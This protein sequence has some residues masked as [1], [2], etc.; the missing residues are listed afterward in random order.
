MMKHSGLGMHEENCTE[1]DEFLKT[2]FEFPSGNLNDI[3]NYI[4]QDAKLERIIFDLPEIISKEF[5]KS[6]I[7]LDFMS[8]T[9]PDE[10]VLQISIKTPFDGE[11]TSTK[12]DLIVDELLNNYESPKNYYFISMEF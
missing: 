6:P 7:S 3:C 4:S 11:T 2:N 9:L 1:L 5:S 10:T 12:K 8:Y